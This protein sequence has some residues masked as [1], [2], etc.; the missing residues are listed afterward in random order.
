MV[1]VKKN[2]SDELIKRREQRTKQHW[3]KQVLTVNDRETMEYRRDKFWTLTDR[4]KLCI[5][6]QCHMLL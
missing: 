3:V 2:G 5:W 6:S 4:W 1:S